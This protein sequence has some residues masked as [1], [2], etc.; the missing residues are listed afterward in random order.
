MVNSLCHLNIIG[1]YRNHQTQ[2][3][4]YNNIILGIVTLGFGWHNNHH[5]DAGR[6]IL[7]E[8]WWELDLEGY[9]G[10]VLS[11]IFKYQ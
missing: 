7:T 10:L 11:K 4:S 9:A 2:D 3:Q 1:S 6:L 8:K 5:N